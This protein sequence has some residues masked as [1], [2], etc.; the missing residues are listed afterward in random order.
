[1]LFCHIS[2]ITTV[3]TILYIQWNYIII[4]IIMNNLHR[5]ICTSSKLSIII[6]RRYSNYISRIY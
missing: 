3:K 2:N 4:F 5:Q 1:M 6:I